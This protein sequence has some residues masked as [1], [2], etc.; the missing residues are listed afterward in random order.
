MGLYDDFNNN[1]EEE[2]YQVKQSKW[3]LR[4]ELIYLGIA[5]ILVF[6]G[7]LLLYNSNRVKVPSFANMS[8]GQVNEWGR[9]NGLLI[10]TKTEFSDDIEKS[11]IISQETPAGTIIS[12]NST[13]EVVVSGGKD[14]QKELIT[15]VFKRMTE[16]EISKW[17]IENDISQ[18]ELIYEY[19]STIEKGK[20]ISTVVD[21]I[22]V[23][24][25]EFVLKRS[26]N[27]K[28]II[29]KG[30]KDK[31]QI[32]VP[33]FS[34]KSLVEIKRIIEEDDLNVVI[35][36]VFSDSIDKGYFVS[37]SKEVGSM[38]IRN[39]EIEVCISKG[40]GLKVINFGKYNRLN[41]EEVLSKEGFKY[42]VVE[43]YSSSVEYGKLISQSKRVGAVINYDELIVLE[44]SLAKVKIGNYLGERYNDLIEFIEKCN[45]KYANIKLD[46][47]YVSTSS[48]E[49][50]EDMEPGTII[51]ISKLNEEVSVGETISVIVLK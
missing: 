12:K 1:K 3:Y 19:S 14:P 49:E 43:R 51:E 46:V 18:Y 10:V 25:E 33:D 29:S 15:P 31:E 38:M 47:D 13:I 34:G 50:Y 20:F 44:Y 9:D 6:S 16:E 28:V 45:M 27:I 32:S 11:F 2:Y 17:F 26:S 22:T 35:K 42:I 21:G 40:K 48:S 8:N 4:K 36:E 5:L 41:V 23:D 24:E 7:S 39:E 30:S 37:Q